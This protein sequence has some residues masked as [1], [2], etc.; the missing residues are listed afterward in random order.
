MAI[1]GGAGKLADIFTGIT[2][3]TT[4]TLVEPNPLHS[5]NDRVKIKHSFFDE[6]FKYEGDVDTVVFSQV[7]EH[8]Y[9]PNQF[10]ESIAEILKARSKTDLRLS[11][12]EI[13][14]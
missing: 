9:D 10:V 7:M 6:N 3:D 14:A 1:G 4:W 8:A 2:N 13:V 12:S 11:E 5:G